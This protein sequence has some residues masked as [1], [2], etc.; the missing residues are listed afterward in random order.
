M[1]GG[2]WPPGGK[3]KTRPDIARRR[4]R[5][6][7][8]ESCYRTRKRSILRSD[9][10]YWPSLRVIGILVRTPRRTETCVTPTCV[11]PR[12][13]DASRDFLF[14]SE[15]AAWGEAV[16]DFFFSLFRPRAGLAQIGH[17]R[18]ELVT[19]AQNLSNN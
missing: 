13:V 4:E 15:R 19:N 11:A 7:D 16:P 1:G 8:W 14:F 3:R 2:S 9:T 18:V 12:H 5:Q 10:H 6:R 17:H